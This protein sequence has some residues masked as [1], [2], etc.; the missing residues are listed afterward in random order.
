MS[1]QIS[2]DYIR[3]RTIFQPIVLQTLVSEILTLWQ[4]LES[5]FTSDLRK[6]IQYQ[7]YPLNCQ[8][9]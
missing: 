2:K 6:L 7:I 8:N 4:K 5:T 1:F 3:E 9:L